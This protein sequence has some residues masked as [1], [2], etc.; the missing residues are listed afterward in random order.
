MKL[1]FETES[2]AEKL[3][4]DWKEKETLILVRLAV[5]IGRESRNFR[6]TDKA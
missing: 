4:G 3:K 2:K 6:T 5:A 1:L